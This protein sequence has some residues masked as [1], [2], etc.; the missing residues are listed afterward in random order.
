[1]DQTAS[2][3]PPPAPPPPTPRAS[4]LSRCCAGHESRWPLLRSVTITLC[5]LGVGLGAGAVLY[6]SARSSEA[7]SISVVFDTACGDQTRALQTA[8]DNAAA[9]GRYSPCISR[10]CILCAGV[11]VCVCLGAGACA[12]SGHAWMFLEWSSGSWAV[13]D[14]LATAGTRSQQSPFPFPAPTPDYHPCTPCRLA[15]MVSIVALS[16]LLLREGV[17]GVGFAGAGGVAGAGSTRLVATN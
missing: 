11:C 17:V 1:M 5:I 16:M 9:G 3:P 15:L 7:R 13:F 6:T 10:L 8:I 2:Q 14:A 12:G 4:A